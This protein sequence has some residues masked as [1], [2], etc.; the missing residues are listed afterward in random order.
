MNN[1]KL[2][3]L[4]H[5]GKSTTI[6]RSGTPVTANVIALEK[7]LSLA[8][9]KLDERYNYTKRLNNIFNYSN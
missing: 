6:Y 9:S 5:G 7:A 2:I 3:P 4:I 8:I 1:Q